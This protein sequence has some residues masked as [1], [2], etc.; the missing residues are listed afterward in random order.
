MSK[1]WAGKIKTVLNFTQKVIKVCNEFKLRNSANKSVSSQEGLPM[2]V[3]K[4]ITV[5]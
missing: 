2:G 4:M 5:Y 3:N 1:W